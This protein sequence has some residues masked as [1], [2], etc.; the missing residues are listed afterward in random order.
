MGLEGELATSTAAQ[1]AAGLKRKSFSAAE[2]CDASIS[3]IEALDPKIN[4]VV[5][6]DFERARAEARMA[7]NLIA[8]G[9][10]RALLG[11]P[12]TVKESFDLRGHPTTWGFPEF[13]EHRAREDALAVQRLKAA[14]AVVLGKTNVPPALADWQS[15][16]PIY[17]RTNNPHNL[18][19][20][21]GGSSGGSASAIAMG[22]SALEVGSDIGGS[23]RIPAAFCG[24]YGHKASYG[25]IPMG[26][27]NPGGMQYAPQLLS[28]LG[29]IARSADDLVS[30]L[31]VIAGPDAESPANKL[32]M[33]QPRHARLSSFRV[34]VIDQHPAVMADAD[35]RGAIEDLADD[36]TKAG[37]S[38][39][40]QSSLLPDLSVSWRTYQAMLH[41]IVTRRAANN[42]RA[43]ITAHDW[44]GHLDDQLRI[45]R[46]WSDFFRHFDVVLAPAFGTPAF[47]HSDEQDWRKRELMMDGESSNFG[48]QLAWAGIATVANLPSTAVPLGVNKAGLPLSVQVIGPFLEDKTTIAFAKLLVRECPLPALAS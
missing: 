23:V 20:S 34:F 30:V 26:G 43:P 28:V 22:F 12:M 38:V 3:R 17:G 47:P 11:I 18:A 41:T 7:D 40:R 2:L 36:L 37:A 42:G 16:N 19:Y 1:L 48:A 13:F 27:H 4:A 15:A 25:V 45:R 9:E 33:P 46:Q 5:V 8:R 31:D 29:P 35:I 6:R 21:A 44:L 14:G 32:V 24:V 10:T 39:A